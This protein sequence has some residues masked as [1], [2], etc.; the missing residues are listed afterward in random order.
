MF[1]F[2]AKNPAAPVS[3]YYQPTPAQTA[4]SPLSTQTPTPSSLPLD[5]IF[6]SGTTVNSQTTSISGTTLPGA[7]VFVN[8]IQLTADARGVF[9]TP[10]TLDEGDNTVVV[11][12]NDAQGNHVEKEITVTYLLNE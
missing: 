8:E 1:V 3:T 12:A 5:L 7:E 6:P 4:T 10:L 9:S 11:S 2:K